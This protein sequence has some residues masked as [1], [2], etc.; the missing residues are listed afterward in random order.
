MLSVIRDKA[1]SF[2]VQDIQSAMCMLIRFKVSK[3]PGN[4][5]ASGIPVTLDFA[6]IITETKSSLTLGRVSC[7]AIQEKMVM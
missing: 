5:Q 4:V 3:L 6:F 2:F 1:K 7:R